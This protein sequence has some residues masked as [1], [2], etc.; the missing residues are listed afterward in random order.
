MDE[1]NDL[2][3]GAGIS[4][5]PID[6]LSKGENIITDVLIKTCEEKSCQS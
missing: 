1:K 6:K 5:A 4:L 2:K 3:E